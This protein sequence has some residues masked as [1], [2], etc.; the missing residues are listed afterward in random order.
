MPIGQLLGQMLRVFRQ[1]LYRRAETAGAHDIREAH[2]QVF[3]AID[4][5]GTR[6]TELA[7][8]S[9]MTPPSMSE[10]VDELQQLGYMERLPDPTDGRAKLI[11]PTRQGRRALVYALRVIEEIEREYADAV[12]AERF[13]S[14]T[15][16]LHA[17]LE[18]RRDVP[19]SVEA[20]G[21]GPLGSGATL[22]RRKARESS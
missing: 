7:V 12:G 8:R 6:L 11:R 1:D 4:W 14:M 3:G 13:E 19:G 9:N 20:D 15:S 18:A 22:G 21:A 16:T 2:L 10:L 17:L 5:K